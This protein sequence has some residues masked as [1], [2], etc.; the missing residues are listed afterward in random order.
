[1][2]IVLV[3]VH[4]KPEMVDAFIAATQLNAGNS[5]HESG[6][7]R[8]DFLQQAE[9]PTRF[10]LYEVYKTPEDHL[11]HRETKH[12][13]TWRDTVTSMMADERIGIR[14][15]NIQPKDMDWK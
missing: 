10:T 6:V 5:I 15:K 4:V 8:F 3:H 11:K 12:Y 2:H 13:L 1:M 14:Y 7:V 9:D